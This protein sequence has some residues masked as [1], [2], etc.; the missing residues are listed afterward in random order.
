LRLTI[1]LAT[2]LTLGACTYSEAPPTQPVVQTPSPVIVQAQ[3]N[4]S[5][6]GVI[7]TPKEY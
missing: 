5:Q 3:P 1:L 7:V 2:L 6:S 4:V